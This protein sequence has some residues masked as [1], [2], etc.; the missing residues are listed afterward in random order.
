[1]SGT[2]LREPTPTWLGLVFPAF[3]TFIANEMSNPMA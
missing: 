3:V 2:A 1:M